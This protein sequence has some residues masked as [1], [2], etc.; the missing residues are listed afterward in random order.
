MRGDLRGTTEVRQ[1]IIKRQTSSCFHSKQRQLW[2]KGN[3][4]L[5]GPKD[6]AMQLTPNWMTS[7]SNS[8][9]F[10]YL[11]RER[12]RQRIISL[13]RKSVQQVCCAAYFRIIFVGGSLVPIP[14]HWHIGSH[15]VMTVL[16]IPNINRRAFLVPSS[17]WECLSNTGKDE[18]IH[19][20]KPGVELNLECDYLG[21]SWNPYLGLVVQ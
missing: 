9:C 13:L 20:E 14:H 21:Q 11:E 8:P 3:F 2:I 4:R 16:L 7:T 6:V 10:L 5:A 1:L 18:S 19:W 12:G 15:H 17:I